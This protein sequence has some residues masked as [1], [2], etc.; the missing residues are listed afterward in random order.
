[1]SSARSLEII[2]EAVRRFDLNGIWIRDDEFHVDRTRTAEICEGLLE[3]NLHIRWYTAG[4]RVDLFNRACDEEIAL[5]RR[6]GAYALKFGVESGS[7]RILELIDKGVTWQEALEANRQAKKHGIVFGFS[8]MMG[9]PTETMEEIHRTV[10]LGRKIMA[11]NPDAQLETIGTYTPLAGTPLFSL[12]CEHGLEPPD[13]L[14][15]WIDWDFWEYDLNGSRI[16]WFDYRGRKRIGNIGYYHTLAHALPNL[17][18]SVS[19][20]SL[21]RTFK[22]LSS[23]VAAYSR[24]RIRHRQFDFAPELAVF[25]SIRER[26][27]RRGGLSLQ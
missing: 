25:R 23:P 16:P 18:D 20:P 11:D 21:R 24:H 22:A 27:L 13:C 6:S 1:M 12:A 9:F 7:N 26:L 4:T 8:L 14:E 2:E 5:L 3:K 19:N 17:I 15:G 10:D